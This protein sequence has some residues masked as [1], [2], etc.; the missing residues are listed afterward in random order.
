MIRKKIAVNSLVLFSVAGVFLFAG[1]AFP[2]T[3]KTIPSDAISK[4]PIRIGY[5]DGGR[6]ALLIRAYRNKE[7]AAAGLPVGLY[8]TKLRSDQYELL[9]PDSKKQLYDGKARGT[10]LTD[11]I[12]AGIVDLALIGESSFIESMYAGKPIVAIAEL[13]H[14][15]KEQSGHVL[16]LRIGIGIKSPKDLLGK[17][18]V[19]RRAG[20]GDG[21]F[22]K[23]FLDK[24][25]VDIKKDILQLSN[26]SLPKNLNEKKKLPKDKIIVIDDLYEDEMEAGIANGVIDGG[27]FHLVTL[28]HYPKGPFYLYAPLESWADPEL[29]HA[30]LVCRKDYLK[31][32]TPDLIKLIEVYI[33]R[34]KYEHSLTYE[35][36]TYFPPSGEGFPMATNTY[37]LNYPQY[38]LIPTVNADLLY[39]MQKLLVKYSAL[40]YKKI[41]IEDFIDNSLVL[42]AAKN[43]CITE[44]DD[45]WQ[46]KY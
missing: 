34:I 38:D 40:G 30:V 3:R 20:P 45:Y 13:G 24:S 19:S 4:K 44:K 25:G 11:A 17:V 27:Y 31:K 10:E 29:S 23:S 46:S 37:G 6:T 39:G 26:T 7:F 43:L 28:V 14:D 16:L 42:Q 21:A 33:K 18:L 1:N 36:R 9:M 41:K 35:E 5:F 22:L 15:V 2:G 8:S 12:L 32:H